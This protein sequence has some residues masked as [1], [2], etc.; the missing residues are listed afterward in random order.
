[1]AI[2]KVSDPKKLLLSLAMLQAEP[3]SGTWYFRGQGCSTFKLLPRLFREEQDANRRQVLEYYLLEWL[4]RVL[5]ERCDLSERLM[6]D[7]N[8]LLAL[9]QHHG[10]STRMLDWTKSPAVAAYFAASSA[11][12]L[13]SK[14]FSVFAVPGVVDGASRL[15]GSQFIEPP[16]GLNEN[17]AAQRGMF[18]KCAWGLED[19]WDEK[20]SQVVPESRVRAD[21]DSRF[22]QFD[23]PTSSAHELISVLLD[24][25]VEGTTLFPG[26]AG[27][28]ETAVT[29]LL[30]GVQVTERTEFLPET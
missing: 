11:L 12:R 2:C 16:V 26:N 8:Y 14:E 30:S 20:L 10:A 24:H 27:L 25:G 23:F 6:S 1:M 18:L 4:R 17:M 9:A 7:D 29:L 15:S 5:K 22:V 21:V 13:S 19:L 28:V 3:T